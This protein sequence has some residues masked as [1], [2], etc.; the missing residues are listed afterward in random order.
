M[1]FIDASKAFYRVNHDKV[2][3]KMFDV[4]TVRVLAYWYADQSIQVKSATYSL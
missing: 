3:T 1:Y 4:Y 2:F